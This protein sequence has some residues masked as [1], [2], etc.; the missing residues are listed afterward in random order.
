MLQYIEFVFNH[1]DNMP[2]PNADIKR[3]S[4]LHSWYK[5]LGEFNRAYPLLIQGEEP[6]YNFSPDLTDENRENF[7]WTVIMDYAL[8][9]YGIKLD[10]TDKVYH[11]PDAVKDFMKCFPIYLDSDFGRNSSE[12]GQFLLLECEMVCKEFWKE[13]TNLKKAVD[14]AREEKV[15]ESD[16]IT[17]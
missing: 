5:H 15:M 16:T 7:H 11:I 10:D 8:D 4:T 6:R 13:L 1:L 17:I 9:G 2:D 14:E 3:I 12:K